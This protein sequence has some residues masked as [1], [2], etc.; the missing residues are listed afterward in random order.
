[1]GFGQDQTAIVSNSILKCIHGIWTGQ[2]YV[3]KIKKELKTANRPMIWP[4]ITLNVHGLHLFVDFGGNS[5]V[6][7]RGIQLEQTEVK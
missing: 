6:Q 1:V 4:I 2:T 7:W 5:G 3:E